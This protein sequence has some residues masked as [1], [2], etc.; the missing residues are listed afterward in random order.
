M[1]LHLFHWYIYIMCG[2]VL[3]TIQEIKKLQAK[4]RELAHILQQL[5]QQVSLVWDSFTQ[6][7]S[8]YCD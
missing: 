5:R 8:V 4:D 2:V 6:Y 7:C 1:L 3:L